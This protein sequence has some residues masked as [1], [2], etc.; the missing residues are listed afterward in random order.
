M[1]FESSIPGKWVVAGEHAVLRGAQAVSVPLT[2]YHLKI[3]FSSDLSGK[4]RT[5]PSEIQTLIT[6]LIERGH[7]NHKISGE[8][9]LESTI[10]Q[11][12]GLGSSAALCVGI[13][14]L[15]HRQLQLSSADLFYTARVLENHFHGESSGMDIATVLSEGPILYSKREGMR[16][17]QTRFKPQVTFHD[18]GLRSS[19]RDCISKVENF[20]LSHSEKGQK[21]DEQMNGASQAALQAFEDYDLSK[22]VLAFER[23]HSCFEEWGLIPHSVQELRKK[24]L[25]EGALA[26][27]LTGAGG[28]GFLVALW[29]KL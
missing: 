29:G 21:L 15:I 12:A 16:P 27:K 22:L 4:L 11:G 18:T 19:T 20:N 5:Q 9:T 8:L 2:Q 24:L 23:A 10:P 17:I 7:A 3:K 13:A 14:Q 6:D 25:K 1:L 28:G 26:V